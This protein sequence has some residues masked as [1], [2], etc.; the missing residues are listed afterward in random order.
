MK[1]INYSWRRLMSYR[2]DWL[3]HGNSSRYDSACKLAFYTHT[4][5]RIH[6]SRETGDWER[7]WD[8]THNSRTCLTQTHGQDD[9]RGSPELS[10]WSSTLTSWGARGRTLDPNHQNCVDS[11]H[12]PTLSILERQQVFLATPTQTSLITHPTSL[13]RLP[14]TSQ[15]E[16]QIA[17]SRFWNAGRVPSHSHHSLASAKWSEQEFQGA[18]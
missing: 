15:N 16:N 13:A 8:K 17:E 4:H 2:C 12:G 1:A 7:S 14:A 3:Q 18:I 10:L 6:A 5:T 11:L 9:P